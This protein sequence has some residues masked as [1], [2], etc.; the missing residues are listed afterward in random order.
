MMFAQPIDDSTQ[1]N[2]QDTSEFLCNYCNFNTTIKSSYNKHILTKKHKQNKQKYFD[3][4]IQNLNTNSGHIKNISEILKN[5]EISMEEL[6]ILN[7]PFFIIEMN[8]KNPGVILK[9]FIQLLFYKLSQLPITESPISVIEKEP[10]KIFAMKFDDK[11]NLYISNESTDA[12]T[13]KN[14]CIPFLENCVDKLKLY[15]KAD[16]VICE[17]VVLFLLRGF[18]TVIV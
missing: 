6:D 14:L 1:N 5:I 4:Y 15:G 13:V 3:D 12:I 11:W 16:F 18:R 9:E 7:N 2:T 10:E 8:N 17:L